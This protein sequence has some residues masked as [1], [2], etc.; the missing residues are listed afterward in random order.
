MASRGSQAKEII[1]NKILETFE[2]SFL[3]D[4]GKELRIPIME[5]G[6]LCQ[7]KISMTCAKTNVEGGS[8]VVSTGASISAS[9]SS[10]EVPTNFMNAPSQE[11]KEAV[12]SL[13]KKLGLTSS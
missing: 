7:I 4:G 2:G 1:K 6:E 3:Y 10:K 11:E 9:D 12:A 13:C 8:G 5:G